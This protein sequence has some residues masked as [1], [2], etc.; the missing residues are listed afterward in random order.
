[1]IDFNFQPDDAS[2]ALISGDP[3]LPEQSALLDFSRVVHRSIDPDV[4]LTAAKATEEE[5]EGAEAAESDPDKV[6]TNARRARPEDGLLSDEELQALFELSTR[7]V[8]AYDEGQRIGSLDIKEGVTFQSR[9]N[10]PPSRH[11]AFEPVW[12]SYTHV[13]IHEKWDDYL[14]INGFIQ[15]WETILGE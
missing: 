15:Y 10:I 9:Q 12:T 3:L 11:G 14:F 7:P 4:P 8:S 13:R 1:M 5:D 2:Y 6:I